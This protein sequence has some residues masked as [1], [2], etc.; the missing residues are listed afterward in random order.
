MSC[1]WLSLMP[2]SRRSL[3][4]RVV[5]VF[6]RVVGRSPRESN[7]SATAASEP[8]WARMT[9]CSERRSSSAGGEVERSLWPRRSSWL[10]DIGRGK[11]ASSH[12]REAGRASSSASSGSSG[13]A[14]VLRAL[15][16]VE[17]LE[18]DLDVDDAAPGQRKLVKAL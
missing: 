14:N 18:I 3:S 6:S 5:E 8:R 16:V 15:Q 4:S 1:T 7:P 17:D 11:A 13:T 12:K 10:R 2:D 9:S